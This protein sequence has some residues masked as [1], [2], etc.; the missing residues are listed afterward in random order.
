VLAVNL[1]VILVFYKELKIVAFDPYLATTLGISAAL[2]HYGLMGAVAMT[3]VAAFESVGSILVVA[4]LITPGATAHLLTDRLGRMLVL[5][6]VVGIVAAVVGYLLALY[7]NTSVAGMM[8]VVAGVEF[9]LAVF[10]APRHGYVSKIVHQ[11]SLS[12][13]I[14]REDVLGMLYRW[15]EA[16][17]AAPLR[18]RQVFEALGGGLLTRL[19]VWSLARRGRVSA[20]PAGALRLTPVGSADAGS[21]IRSH[22]LWETYL[23]RQLQVPID[24]VHDPAMRMEHFVTPRIEREI[25]AEVGT[26]TDPHGRDI[27]G[28]G[29]GARPSQ[30]PNGEVP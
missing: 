13:R 2:V 10:F 26:R 4:M 24:R 22:R 14:V 12:L 16:G 6:A 23:A 21:L 25:V 17:Q 5:S 18:R 8:S 7:W 1:V 20:E 28:H 29:E 3:T 19:A 11:A 30:P 15:Q 27:P 9:A